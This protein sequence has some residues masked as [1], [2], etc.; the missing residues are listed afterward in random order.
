LVGQLHVL[1]LLSRYDAAL[2]TAE[3][4]RTL[5]ER[6][7][8]DAYLAKLAMNLANLHFR[9]DDH[10]AALEQ[11]TRAAELFDRLGHRDPVV[12]GLEI[13]RA[14]ALS[15]V[16][17]PEEALQR[18]DQLQRECDEAGLDLLGAQVRMN[19]AFVH[20]QRGE[21]DRALERL[22]RA[23]QYFRATNHPAF[24]A[25]S[26]LNR[27]E[28]YYHL[29]L[30][31]ESRLLAAEAEELFA[32]EG[33]AYDQG[34]ALH[35]LALSAL[36][37]GN[38][39]A[40]FR[41]IRRG[42]RLFEAE[43]NPARV[44]LMRLLWGEALFQQ[45]RIDEAWERARDSASAFRKLGLD[46]WESAATVLLAR[47]DAKRSRSKRATLRLE[48]ALGR[49]VDRDQPLVA[50]RLHEAL[51]SLRD[52]EGD[53][54]RALPHY[55]SAVELLESLRLRIP[56]EDSKISFLEDKAHLFDRLL[57]LELGTRRPSPE[58]IFNLM[59]RSR[60]QS[61]WDR[62]RDPS[63]RTL[64]TL[65]RN[66]SGEL[67]RKSAALRSELSWL[68]V[69]IS[70]LE[71][72]SARERASTGPLRD[73]VREREREWQRLVREIRERE[74]GFDS[75]AGSALGADLDSLRESLPDGWGFLTFHVG[76][77]FAVGLAVDRDRVVVQHLDSDLSRLLAR[78]TEQL[79]FQWGAAALEA[80]WL[81]DAGQP[82]HFGDDHP[83]LDSAR[84][85]LSDLY[86]AIW[87][88]LESVLRGRNW[89]ISPH[90][91]LHRIP[92]PALLGPD[93]HLV[94]RAC[95]AM[96]PSARIWKGIALRDRRPGWKSAWIA[97]V[98][99]EQ[100][101]AISDEIE[102]VANHL[103]GWNVRRDSA[104]TRSSFLAASRDAD[105]IHLAAHG[106]LRTD[107]PAFS[108]LQLSDGPLFVHD[109]G[110]LRLPGSLVV[111]TACSS[112]RGERLAGD[113]WVGLAQ[114]FLH[115]GA[116]TVVTSLWPIEDGATASLMDGFYQSLSRGESIPESLRAAML[117][118][119]RSLVHP[120]QWASFST[121]GGLGGPTTEI[122]KPLSRTGSMSPPNRF[123]RPRRKTRA[124]RWRDGIPIWYPCASGALTRRMNSVYSRAL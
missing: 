66:A 107:N 31:E 30:V 88:P 6:A 86:R 24:T 54:A 20:S 82:V 121:T 76:P 123:L 105:L 110:S 63:G 74:G 65:P 119:S 112:G 91:M 46:R 57:A 36:A 27:A 103:A 51:G 49:T 64:D 111:L 59:E 50:Y 94:E 81:R 67:E 117:E 101:P 37:G 77:G 44:A 69:R 4:A 114:A 43:R 100:L 96:T 14:V 84:A 25:H 23:I 122:P 102:S 104:P 40:A 1:T 80:A 28:I 39:R 48:R 87:E 62:F 99:S 60:A 70:R 106:A 115:A 79:D 71:V 55:E 8:D 116:S 34:Q 21:F 38:L 58:R 22:G 35:Q 78:Q 95:I 118:T 68:H 29:N 108:Q 2:R 113:E 52:E 17:R 98:C 97:G 124:S 89:I 15:N 42:T 109:L 16:D 90:G 93:G 10:A 72:G 26:L 92:F 61:L 56:T 73:Q 9:R 33:M 11:C 32:R 53:T 19:A 18:F 47:I 3:E 120:W 7:G 5:L 41:A 12:L 75:A 83:L 45:G 13:N 85:S